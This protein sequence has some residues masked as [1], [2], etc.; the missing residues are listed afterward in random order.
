MALPIIKTVTILFHHKLQASIQSFLPIFLPLLTWWPQGTQKEPRNWAT[1]TL[2][3]SRGLTDL[4]Y[5]LNFSIKNF[6]MNLLWLAKPK[7][8]D[9]EGFLGHPA[10]KTIFP[11]FDRETRNSKITLIPNLT[12]D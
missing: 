11:V 12:M 10:P 5:F 1:S 7:T 8:P 4:Q 2:E 6:I 9:S 3:Q